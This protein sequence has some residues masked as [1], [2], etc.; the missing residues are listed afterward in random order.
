[1][2]QILRSNSVQSSVAGNMKS[3]TIETLIVT[4]TEPA[5][6][7]ISDKEERAPIIVNGI[8]TREPTGPPWDACPDILINLATRAF[9]GLRWDVSEYY[10]P[11]AKAMGKQFRTAVVRTSE[12]YFDI[13]WASDEVDSLITAQLLD[14]DWYYSGSEEKLI[15]VGVSNVKHILN[16]FSLTMPHRFR[17][18]VLSL[19]KLRKQQT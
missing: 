1:M 2:S 10:C 8:A 15:A 4:I 3:E 16:T 18:P 13:L 14:D 5:R 19:S 9:M 7:Y 6:L 11:L 17:V 12:Q